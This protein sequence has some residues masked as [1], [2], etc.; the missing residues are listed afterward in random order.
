[1]TSDELSFELPDGEELVLPGDDTPDPWA[2][3]AAEAPT[4][5]PTGAVP[6]VTAA[7]PPGAVPAAPAV[8]PPRPSWRDRR[9]ARKLRARRVRRLVRH[10]EPWS[11]LKISLI[12][13]F[14]LWGILL[15]AGVLLWGV[16]VSSGMIDNLE[17]F[18]QELFALESFEFNADQ[19]F[20]ASAMG[21]LVLVVAASGFTV[22]MAV[23]FNLISDVTGGVRITVVEEETARP[24]PRRTRV[25]AGVAPTHAID[26]RTGLPLV[27]PGPGVGAAP[28]APGAPLVPTPPD[29]PPG[30]LGGGVE[31][32]TSTDPRVDP[33]GAPVDPP[34][35]GTA[36]VASTPGDR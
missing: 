33:S 31:P 8:T 10:V 19:I 26:P 14:C 13:Y 30:L 12:F 3:G 21:G 2:P 9:A 34:G 18:I 29:G 6:P 32:G 23:L 11:V 1:M 25:R 5:A 28:G 27:G 7:A 20:R 35:P 15:I 24:R 36:E 22:L 17:T 16:A 4:T